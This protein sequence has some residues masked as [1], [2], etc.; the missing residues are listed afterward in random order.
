MCD[1]VAE[2]V[3]Q[4]PNAAG[5]VAFNGGGGVSLN[6]VRWCGSEGGSPP[7]WPTIWSTT[8]CEP[9]WCPAGSG[10][11][12]PPNATNASW[13]PSG[14]DATIQLNDHWFFTPDDGLHPIADLASFYHRSVGANGHLEIDFAID[15]TG[16]IAPAH[17]ATYAAF[18]AW[19]KGCYSTPVATGSIA[20]GQNS[21]V[22]NVNGDI[23]NR[24]MMIEN[25]AG[26][27]F[28]ID[29]TV[30]V[31]IGTS[32]GPFSSGKT[33]GAKRIDVAASSSTNVSAVRVTIVSAFAPG[34]NGVEVKVFSGE[35]CDTN[36][37]EVAV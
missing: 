6:P 23:V 18:G 22:I 4:L 12:A 8:A 35:G 16:R 2:R 21:V 9:A 20:V 10:S 34:H 36:A 37:Y 28:V 3:Q 13:Y 14:V 25:I 7:G 27:Q 5:A 11:G 17:A 15:R 32:W 29:Y 24:V 19:I 1:A 31:L 33:I 30:E 26:G